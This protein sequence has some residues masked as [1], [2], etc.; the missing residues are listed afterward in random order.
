[1]LLHMPPRSSPRDGRTGATS[2]GA[3]VFA[4]QAPTF[5]VAAV[6]PAGTH[7]EVREVE[8]SSSGRVGARRV[9]PFS[10]KQSQW[11][12][13]RENVP[14]V[15]SVPTTGGGRVDRAA[16]C[17]AERGRRATNMSTDV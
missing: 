2:G 8:Q 17:R 1:M 16:A 6:S 9:L 15:H 13:S 5:S 4:L 14:N 12:D 11:R 7:S 3:P 10:Q